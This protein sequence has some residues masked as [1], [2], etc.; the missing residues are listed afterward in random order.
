MWAQS[1]SSS[2]ERTKGNCLRGNMSYLAEI[3]RGPPEGAFYIR[4]T[5]HCWNGMYGI[6]R[7]PQRIRN[8][9]TSAVSYLP[10]I[11]GQNE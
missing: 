11:H 4:E 6:P 7:D 2:D 10:A 3:N 1:E 8:S 9:D 5:I